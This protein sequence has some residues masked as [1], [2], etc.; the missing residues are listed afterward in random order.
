MNVACRALRGGVD[1]EWNSIFGSMAAGA[2]FRRHGTYVDIGRTRV[3]VRVCVWCAILQ[4]SSRV[5][6]V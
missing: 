1:D 2:F 4:K 3:C 6:V 5:V